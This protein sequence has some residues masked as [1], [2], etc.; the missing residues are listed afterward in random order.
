AAAR[1]IQDEYFR[2]EA[3]SALADSLSQMP[4]AEL[5]SLWQ[6]TLDELS[7][8]TRPNLLQDIEALF[9][10]IF[11][12]SGKAATAEIARAIVDVGRWWK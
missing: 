9:P 10:V 3:L 11:A 4:A 5:F 6:D 12:L 8:R 7:L 1:A 2:A